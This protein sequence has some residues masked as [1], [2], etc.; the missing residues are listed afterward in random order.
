MT[1]FQ[2]LLHNNEIDW[3]KIA[4][5]GLYEIYIVYIERLRDK[6]GESQFDAQ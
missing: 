4:I 5:T 3:P 6:T 1:D 2:I